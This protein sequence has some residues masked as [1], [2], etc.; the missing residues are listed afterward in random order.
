M[1]IRKVELKNGNL[2]INNSLFIGDL[3]SMMHRIRLM[4]ESQLFNKPKQR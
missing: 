1:K 4:C 3:P 2:Y